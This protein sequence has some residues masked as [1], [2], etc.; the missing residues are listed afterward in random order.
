MS[1]G[2]IVVK[3]SPAWPSSKQWNLEWVHGQCT[4]NLTQLPSTKTWIRYPGASVYVATDYHPAC[5]MSHFNLWRSCQQSLRR[6]L[7]PTIV[8][9]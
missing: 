1:M 5:A 4:R 8:N 3:A 2:E 9:I 7:P 6:D